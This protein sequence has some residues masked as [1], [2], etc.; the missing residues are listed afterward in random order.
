MLLGLTEPTAGTARVDGVIP[1]RDPL[2]VKSRVGYLPDEVG[3]YE[4]MTARQN[5]RYTAEL[6]RL[7]RGAAADRIDALLDDVGLRADADRKVG[8]VLARHAPAA[9]AGRRPGEGPVDPDPRRADGEHR[10]RGRARAAAARRAPALR[11]GRDGPAVVAPAAPGRAGVRPHRRLRRRA[12]G[13][14]GHDRRAGRRARRPLDLHR[15]RHRC[16]RRA[17][18]CWPP[19]PASPRSTRREGRWQ[20]TAA[21]DVRD[22]AAAARVRGRRQPRRTSL[23]RAPTSTPSTTAGSAPTRRP[24]DP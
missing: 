6:N 12:A 18:G 17:S 7:P 1:T 13:G 10:S 16:A 11:P 22:D 5:L 2:V 15:R 14:G 23:A 21:H 4:D 20:L 19:S 8:G 3:F 9:R 24:R